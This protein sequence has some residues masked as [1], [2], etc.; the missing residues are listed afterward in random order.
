MGIYEQQCQ[1]PWFT[2]SESSENKIIGS[3]NRNPEYTISIELL[4]KEASTEPLEEVKSWYEKLAPEQKENCE[5]KR[6]TPVA[7]K[8][9]YTISVREEVLSGITQNLTEL[10]GKKQYDYLCGLVVGAPL[11][12]H[13]PYFEFD[14]RSVEKYIFVSSYGQD[15]P[16][17]DF[18]TIRF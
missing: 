7:H 13:Q 15:E 9:R 5:I 3:S 8:V 16:P 1:N 17:I 11:T 12:S 10:P 18:E 4:S 6:M 14:E 2:L